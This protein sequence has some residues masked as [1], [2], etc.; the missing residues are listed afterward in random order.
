MYYTHVASERLVKRKDCAYRPARGMVQQLV[1]GNAGVD[2][3]VT[4]AIAMTIR[5]SVTGLAILWSA[6]AGGPLDHTLAVVPCRLWLLVPRLNT[7]SA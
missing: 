4:F 3:L 2:P 6:A 1:K 5:L 7:R